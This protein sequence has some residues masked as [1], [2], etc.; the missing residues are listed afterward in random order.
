MLIVD[1]NTWAGFF[2]GDDTAWV[3]R[4]DT[5]LEE[6]EDLAI[7]PIIVTEVLQ[8]FRTTRGFERARS[9]MTS[10]PV[11]DP[12][13]DVYVEAARTFR[14]LRGKGVTVRG[15]VDCLIA[16]TCIQFDAV[17]LSPDRDFRM[18]ER[19]TRLRLWHASG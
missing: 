17:L 10:I 19:H 4:L 3:R 2:N 18:I 6:E 11:I 5:A 15:A 1:S 13:I 7:L 8:G 14:F 16:Q 12:A 9:V